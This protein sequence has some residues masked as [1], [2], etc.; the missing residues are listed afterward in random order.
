MMTQK[1]TQFI[2]QLIAGDRAT[3]AR[4][5]TIAE[6]GG[7]SA[8]TLMKAI[9]DKNPTPKSI[10]LTGPP[11]SGKSTLINAFAKIA[12]ED[13]QRVAILAVDPSSPISGGA[14]LGDRTRMVDHTDDADIFF[15]S[16]SARG[17]L[18]GLCLN[19]Q[20]ITDIMAVAGWD[21]II[22]ETVGAGQ[23]EVEIA[24]IAD[25]K[26]VISAPGLG[27]DVQ[28]IKAGILEIADILVVNKADK[29][30]ADDTVRHLM[31]MVGL[32]KSSL[33]NVEVMKTIATGH[34]GVKALY[35]EAQ[36]L[37]GKIDNP[38]RESR[39]RQ[40]LLKKVSAHIANHIYTLI[41]HNDND[42][43]DSI[44]SDLLSRKKTLDE[45]ESQIFQALLEQGSAHEHN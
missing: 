5:I 37:L 19:I 29:P 23:S 4:A 22:L 21:L 24:E 25:V 1:L 2:E 18:G 8:E 44:I 35:D 3:L 40:H 43:I 13:K 38:T 11:G 28:A 36:T 12:R 16:V 14:I 27:D 34:E 26:I 10:G 33:A 31:G 20:D 30:G 42:N 32:R 9:S 15:R 6:N 39:K 45:V 7:P 41:A 17:H